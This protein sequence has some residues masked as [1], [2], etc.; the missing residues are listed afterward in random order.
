MIST[1]YFV[2]CEA[3]EDSKWIE[4]G[5]IRS[6]IRICEN[7]ARIDRSVKFAIK[8]NTHNSQLDFHFATWWF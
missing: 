8:Y 2:M 5:D 3:C 1:L 4:N 7:A 6:I